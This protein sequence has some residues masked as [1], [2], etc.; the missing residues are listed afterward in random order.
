MEF[1]HPIGQNPVV[2]HPLLEHDDPVCGRPPFRSP[3]TP[4]PRAARF[5]VG[6][7]RPGRGRAFR[8]QGGLLAERW[9]NGEGRRAGR[10]DGRAGGSCSSTLWRGIWGPSCG[11]RLRRP[12]LTLSRPPEYHHVHAQRAWSSPFRLALF[13]HYTRMASTRTDSRRQPAPRPRVARRV[14]RPCAAWN[15]PAPAG[16]QRVQDRAHEEA[17]YSSGIP[18]G[19]TTVRELHKPAAV[20]ACDI[21]PRRQGRYGASAPLRRV[22]R[23]LRHSCAVPMIPG[24]GS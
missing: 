22:S 20:H 5:G 7:A 10:G 17:R 9:H 8:R 6:D 18:V 11:R 15:D 3:R 12:L 13:A 16:N 4:V 23:P 14:G 1:C 24:S 2:A 21:E 19:S